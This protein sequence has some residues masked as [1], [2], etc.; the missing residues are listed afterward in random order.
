MAL[1]HNLRE[2]LLKIVEDQQPRD[3]YSSSLQQRTVLEEA[4][5]RLPDV[6]DEAILTQWGELF[7]TG[8]LAWG[9][10]IPNPDPPFFHA[11]ELG[12]RALAN[13]TRDPSNPD[14]YLLYLNGLVALS[15]TTESYLREGLDCYVAGHT[16]AAAVMV[17]AA[18]ESIVIE[19]RDDIVRYMN[20][21][22]QNPSPK[23]KEWKIKPI[24]DGL[25]GYI[26]K[27]TPAMDDKLKDEYE[28]TWS[29]FFCYIRMVR[30]EAGHPTCVDP[31]TEDQVH[32]ALLMF[33][34]LA[35]L[36]QKI[37]NWATS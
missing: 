8:L 18:A 23:M 28:A 33:P 10:N 3:A 6:S 26:R 16:K 4:R 24:I 11:T 2:T 5:R 25:D 12:K 20:S 37:S 35:S 9:V 21:N 15:P 30:N 14:G 29:S 36:A 27:R 17:G 32:A 34:S 19:L 7:R 13:A 1:Q 31:I 22:G